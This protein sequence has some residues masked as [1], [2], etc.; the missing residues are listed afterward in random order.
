[1]GSETGGLRQNDALRSKDRRCCAPWSF[2]L[3]PGD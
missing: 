2:R 1:V 3:L